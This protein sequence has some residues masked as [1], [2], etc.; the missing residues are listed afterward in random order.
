MTALARG[1]LFAVV[2]SR[3]TIHHSIPTVCAWRVMFPLLP[4]QFTEENVTLKGKDLH[5]TYTHMYIH[6]QYTHLHSIQPPARKSVL[7]R[8]NI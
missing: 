6:T 2:S 7:V 1:T 4:F 3:L 8:G 5:H